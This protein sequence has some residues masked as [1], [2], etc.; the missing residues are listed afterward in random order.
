M[1]NTQISDSAANAAVDSITALVNN[2]S[3]KFYTAPQPANAN[4]AIGAQTLLVTLALAAAAFQGSVAGVALMNAV[5]NAI[6]AAN[7]A[8]AWF[9]VCKQNGTGVWDGSIGVAQSITAITNANPAVMTCG[10]AHGLT[11]GQKVGLTGF[12]GTW[13]VA[14]GLWA[15]TVIDATHFSIPLDS[16]AFGAIAGA[17]TTTFNINIGST[18][19]R[20]GATM[21]LAQFSFS[22][23]EAGM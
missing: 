21:S 15:V 10:V 17:P 12:T 1:L 13:A 9:R 18:D 3:M 22:L 23:L 16:T 4:T 2:G 7:G 11:S 14:N 20:Q 6:I 5:A 19:L 8:V